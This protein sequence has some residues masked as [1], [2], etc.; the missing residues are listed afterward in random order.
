MTTSLILTA[1][2]WQ[3]ALRREGDPG[4]LCEKGLAK[5]DENEQAVLGPELKLIAEEYIDASPDEVA[6]GVTALR[7]ERFCMLIEPYALISDAM[8]ITLLKDA[9]ALEEALEE[10]GKNEND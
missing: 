7:G 4:G 1:Q 8:K 10:R 9:A 3:F 5:L 6:P 2:E